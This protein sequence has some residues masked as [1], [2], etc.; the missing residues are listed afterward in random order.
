MYQHDVSRERRASVEAVLAR[1][2]T[3]PGYR[4]RLRADAAAAL[5][6]LAIDPA[7]ETPA[8]VFGFGSECVKTCKHTCFASTFPK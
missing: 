2:A 3:D 6:G 1:I 5:R 7:A 4:Q 8:E